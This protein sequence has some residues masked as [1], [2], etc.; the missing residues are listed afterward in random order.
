M[1]K[2]TET[3]GRVRGAVSRATGREASGEPVVRLA[4]HASMRSYWRVGR[5]PASRVVMVMPPNA[6]PEEVTKGGP[7]GVDPFLD[8]QRYLASI[9]VRVPRVDAFYEDDPRGGLMV[10]ED[11]G[12]EM[13]ETRLLAGD[14]PRPLYERAIDALARLRAHAEA[15][16]GGCVAFGRSF[17]HDLYL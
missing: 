6:K 14:P 11:L 13:L 3:E 5:A 1:T 16:P 17:D 12:D 10:L 9:G 4:G 2:D 15:R 8:V 7:T